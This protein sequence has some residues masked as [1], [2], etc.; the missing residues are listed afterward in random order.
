MPVISSRRYSSYLT[1]PSSSSSSTSSSGIG[2][3]TYRSTNYTSSSSLSSTNLPSSSRY[4]SSSDST[5]SYRTYRST[6]GTSSSSTSA[7]DRTTSGTSSYRSRYDYDDTYNKYDSSSSYDKKRTD[8]LLSTRIGVSKK[9]TSNNRYSTICDTLPP[10]PPNAHNHHHP[11]S[12]SSTTNGTSSINNSILSKRSLSRSRDQYDSNNNIT[13]SSSSDS[14]V[15]TSA[16]SSDTMGKL[17]LMDDLEFYEKYS[18]SRYMTK[19]ESAR[20]RSLSDAALTTSNRETSPASSTTSL[21]NTP[22]H[23][24]KSEIRSVSLRNALPTTTRTWDRDYTSGASLYSGRSSLGDS[25]LS[26]SKKLDG[27]DNLYDRKTSSLAEGQCGLWNIGNT[28]FMNSVL[29]CLSHTVDLSKFA[30]SSS[31]ASS[32]I[33]KGSSSSTKDQKIWSE[34]CKLITQMWQ[35]G[36]KSV[37]P[38]DL[39]MALSSKYRMYSGSA[40]QDSQEFL[41]YLLD[42][43]HGALNKGGQKVSLHIE[44]D[45]SDLEK[46]HEMWDWYTKRENSIIKD[47][48]VGQLKSSLY[49]THCEKTSVMFDPFWDLSV[50]VPSTSSNCKLDKCL[51]MFTVKDVLDGNEMPY[52][53]FCK[54]TRKCIKWFTI[55]SFPKYLVIHL[56]RFSEMRWTKLTNIVEFPTG[57]G[58]LDLTPYAADSMEKSDTPP[59]YSLYGISNHMGSTHGGHYVASCKHPVTKKWFEYND[60]FVSETRESSLVSSSAY[61]LFYERV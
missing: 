57:I 46:S 51:E 54:T 58:E 55:Q 59:I 23:T 12:S 26:D 48:F 15:G 1:S 16:K 38:S 60:N 40:Q 49:C 31:A 22:K 56:K 41:R 19:Y 2:S 44:E 4:N 33:D 27:R 43:L 28:C 17:S 18:P 35:P 53:D 45:M 42:A 47:L 6:L 61:L 25:K 9:N 52:C 34:F 39:K 32:V 20:S 11:S 13:K 7:S 5:S 37:N 10:L 24:P 30:R 36:A 3:G 21:N 29:Q 50:P 14:G 8:S